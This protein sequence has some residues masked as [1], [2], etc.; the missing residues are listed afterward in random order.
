MKYQTTPS[1][2]GRLG[3]AV[4]SIL[5]LL[6]ACSTEDMAFEPSKEAIDNLGTQDEEPAEQPIQ[7]TT[8]EAPVYIQPTPTT[9]TT[10]PEKEIH[11]EG[12]M[13][14]HKNWIAL[15][16]KNQIQILLVMLQLMKSMMLTKLS[17]Y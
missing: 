2:N 10:P 11:V 4:I 9:Q 13:L 12:W 14:S 1:L 16:L 3:L 7:E 6:V 5:V 8:E 17:H 15:I